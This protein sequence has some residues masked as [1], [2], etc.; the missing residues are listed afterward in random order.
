MVSYRKLEQKL[1][2]KGIN[3]SELG[4]LAGISSRTI[5]KIGKGEKLSKQT[6][7]KIAEVLGTDAG[8]LYEVESDNALLQ[9]LRE[10]KEY[11]ISNGIYHGAD[12]LS[13]KPNRRQQAY[14]RPD[15]ADFRNEYD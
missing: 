10:E 5:A 9:T 14:G 7:R 15:E 1:D 3:K 8:S 6:L 11:K 13:F 2:E 12:G 4:K